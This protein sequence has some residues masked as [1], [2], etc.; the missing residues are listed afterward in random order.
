MPKTPEPQAVL[1]P[2]TEAAIF[3]VL[4]VNRGGEEATR[5]SSRT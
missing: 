1:T 2:L 5:R 3:L 4:T